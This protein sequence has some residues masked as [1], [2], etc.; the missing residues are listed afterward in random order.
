MPHHGGEI[1]G[2]GIH[3]LAEGEAISR[4]EPPDQVYFF[5]GPHLAFGT[6]SMSIY[7]KER[8]RLQ[9]NDW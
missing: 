5:Q 9:K 8:K 3:G 2:I 4:L 7:E 6:G 1:G